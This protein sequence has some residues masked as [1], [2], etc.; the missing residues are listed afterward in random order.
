[1][2][3]ER[4]ILCEGQMQKNEREHGANLSSPFWGA[5]FCSKEGRR[6]QCVGVIFVLQNGV[7]AKLSGRL[8]CAECETDFYG[9]DEI[10]PTNARVST[11][12]YIN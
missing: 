12:E 4:S 1:M 8:F 10:W 7:N 11:C 6:T 5:M 3:S 2:P 9:L